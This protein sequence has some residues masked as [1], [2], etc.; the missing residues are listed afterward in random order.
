MLGQNLY[1]LT[2]AMLASGFLMVTP[3]QADTYSS[4]FDSI[5]RFVF[6]DG[7]VTDAEYSQALK[8]LTTKHSHGY[9]RGR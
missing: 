2:S 8:A 1:R 3:A 6:S 7:A 4:D 5:V 9:Y